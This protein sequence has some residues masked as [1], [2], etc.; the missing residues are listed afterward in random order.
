[1]IID[2]VGLFN[3]ERIAA[4]SDRAQLL[5]PRLLA[6][7]NGYARLELNYAT[8]IAN[9]FRTFAEPPTEDDLWSVF[10]EYASNFLAVLYEARG[11]WWAEFNTSE[12]FL[13]RYKTKRDEESP[14]PPHEAREKHNAGYLQWKKAKYLTHQRF[15]KFSESFSNP[16]KVSH[17][18]GGGGDGEG[19]GVAG[20]ERPPLNPLPVSVPAPRPA[21]CVPSPGKIPPSPGANGELLVVTWLCE[22]LGVVL[23]PAQRDMAAQ[24]ITFTARELGKDTEGAAEHIRN[25]ALEAR[26]RGEPLDAWYLADGKWRTRGANATNRKSRNE[27]AAEEYLRSI[28]AG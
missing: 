15:R 6:A 16:P 17:G 14:A 26:S 4:C 5:F 7:A 3:G 23:A 24:H 22:E 8:I 28:S 1:M 13:P 25:A 2:P 9:W 19:I 12:K 11:A 18:I 27:L 10:E 20:E 21:K